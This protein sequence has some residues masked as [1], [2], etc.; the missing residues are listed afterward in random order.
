[1]DGVAGADERSRTSDLLITNQLLYQLSYVSNGL[2]YRVLRLA[3]QIKWFASFARHGRKPRG[4]W[5]PGHAMPR[6]KLG[7]AAGVPY[8]NNVCNATPG[9]SARMNASPTKNVFT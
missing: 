5:L 2:N 9:S 8:A 3:R 4:Y 1:M 7:L 6:G